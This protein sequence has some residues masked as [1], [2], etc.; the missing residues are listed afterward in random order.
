MTASASTPEPTV[1]ASDPPLLSIIVPAYN[2]APYVAA[3]IESALDQTYP[4][5]EVIVVNDGSTDRTLEI[6]ESVAALRKDARLKIANRANGGVPA[7]RNTGIAM[8]SGSLI[9]FLDADDIWRPSKAQEQVAHLL[10]DPT[11]GISFSF[12]EYI[13]EDGRRTGKIARPRKPH[14][15]LHDMIRANHVGNG[16]TPIVRRECFDMAGPFNESLR[17]CEDHEMWCRSMWV[18]GL[19]TVAIARPLTLYRVRDSSLSFD[20][21]NFVKYSE[22]A[23]SCLRE[24]LVDVPSYLFRASQAEH[25]RV[26]AWKAELTHRHPDAVRLMARSLRTWPWHFLYSF[27][28]AATSLALF[29]PTRDREQITVWYRMWRD[30]Y[31]AWRDRGKNSQAQTPR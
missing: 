5:L 28:L 21:G 9:G 17:S 16:S 26:A 2:V 19:R 23:T 1:A 10:A 27:H 6:I 22:L 13:E 20:F 4:H 30:R 8:A 29:L 7:A 24:R 11:I 15:T 14:P 12:S 3:A 31:L 18:T 25:Y